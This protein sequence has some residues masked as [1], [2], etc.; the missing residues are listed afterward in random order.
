MKS[1]DNESSRLYYGWIVVA[2]AF[3]ATMMGY[4]ITYSSGVFLKPLYSDFG[5]T[6]AMTAGAFSAY[7][8]SHTVFAAF[9][10]WLTDKWGPRIVAATG[11]ICLA[12]SMIMMSSITTLWE[13]YVYYVFLLGWGVAAAYTPMVTTVSRWF[14]VKRGL[15]ISLTVTGVGTGSLVLSPLAAWLITSYGWRTAYVVVGA[16]VFTVFIPI[17]TFIKKSPRENF[18]VGSEETP[19]AVKSTDDFSF[20]N[21]VKTRSFW[22]LSLSW[23]FAALALWAIYD[24]YGPAYHR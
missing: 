17:V 22:A 11:G 10:G 4:G 14:T 9:A 21:A 7:A 6:R 13:F 24:P 8:V 16:I 20:L 5:W 2:T 23:A 18:K 1:I 12:G 15:A 3:L 19:N